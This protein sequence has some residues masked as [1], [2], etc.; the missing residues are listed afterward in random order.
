MPERL[1]KFI[2]LSETH[3]DALAL[4]FHIVTLHAHAMLP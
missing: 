4:L 2:T 1:A 3:P